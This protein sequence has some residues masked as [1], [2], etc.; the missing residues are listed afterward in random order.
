MAPKFSHT[1]AAFLPSSLSLRRSQPAEPGRKQVQAEK[2][3]PAHLPLPDGLM[4]LPEQ[5]Q[6]RETRQFRKY[7][8]PHQ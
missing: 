8:P 5:E 2:R 6:G 1:P 7:R 3:A 4:L